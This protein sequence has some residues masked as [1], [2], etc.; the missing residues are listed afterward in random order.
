MGY[1]WK[2][3]DN[4]SKVLRP[5]SCEWI[6]TLCTRL[7]SAFM[8]SLGEIDLIA[9]RSILFDHIVKQTLNIEIFV[10]KIWMVTA[11]GHPSIPKIVS[12]VYTETQPFEVYNKIKLLGEGAFGKA[13]LVEC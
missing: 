7:L 5:I 8:I 3:F 2:V 6:A 9:D 1:L 10:K 4:F 12:L 11:F 13:F